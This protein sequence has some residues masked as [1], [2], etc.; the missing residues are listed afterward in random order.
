MRRSRASRLAIRDRRRE[1]ANRIGHRPRRHEHDRREAPR[2]HPE[3]LLE[4]RVRRNEIAVVITRKER[5]GDG[6]ATEN[7]SR[8]D[9]QK[10]QV[11][12]GAPPV[13]ASCRLPHALIDAL[14]GTTA[15]VV[16]AVTCWVADHEP[17]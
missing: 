9:L 6:D 16:V 17:R 2:R 12:G 8:S 5:K 10:S 14:A 13:V 7:V 4:Q 15:S 3:P 11:T 1:N